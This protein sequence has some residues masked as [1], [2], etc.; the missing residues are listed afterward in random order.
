MNTPT[1]GSGA[2]LA[3]PPT[4][5][6]PQTPH[7]TL[8]THWNIAA[9][10][11]RVWN[12]LRFYEELGTPAPLLLRMLLPRPVPAAA[13]TAHPGQETILHYEDGHYARRVVKFEP[14]RNYE[15]EVVEQRLAS[16]RGVRLLGGAFALR[17]L[18]ADHTDLSITTVYSSGL[19]PRWLFRSLETAVCGRLQ[20]HLLVEIEKRAL[21]D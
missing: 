14:P 11:E 7:L 20:R 9:S 17:Q 18:D 8:V 16:D 3:R 5:A 2:A 4:A 1:V 6:I 15:F 13:S 21:K 10:T 19:R 12:S